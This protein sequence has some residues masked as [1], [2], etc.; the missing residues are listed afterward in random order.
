MIIVQA[1]ENWVLNKGI[2]SYVGLIGGSGQFVHN[3][4]DC[5]DTDKVRSEVLESW[6][7]DRLD[8][9]HFAAYTRFAQ[10]ELMAAHALEPAKPGKG[11]ALRKFTEELT[12]FLTDLENFTSPDEVASETGRSAKRPF[13]RR[14]NIL[15]DS[16]VARVL[17]IIAAILPRLAAVNKAVS[18]S[19][20]KPVYQQESKEK[21][22]KKA[23][24]AKRIAESVGKSQVDVVEHLGLTVTETRGD[25]M[26]DAARD[27][28]R[29]HLSA[30][31]LGAKPDDL[32][33]IMLLYEMDPTQHV[34]PARAK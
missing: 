5:F 2:A 21:E 27:L 33:K 15:L 29:E 9:S 12:E 32:D 4:T 22:T 8:A 28:Q 18:S 30:W 20:P 19:E 6:K 14:A 1:E 25:A 26:I 16:V 10:M 13:I 31:V 7:A 23:L 3:I 34:L 24:A 11:G 17:G